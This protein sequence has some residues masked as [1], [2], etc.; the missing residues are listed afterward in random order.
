MQTLIAI[1]PHFPL[2]WPD[3]ARQQREKRMRLNVLTAAV[4]AL[5]AATAT[6]ANAAP[7]IIYKVDKVTAAII[8]GHLVVSAS[9]AVDTGGWFNPRL[10]LKDPHA[11]EGDTAVIEFQATPPHPSTFVIQ[12]LLPLSTTAV[13]PLPHAGT[14]QVRV[15][16]E[17]NS[18]SAPITPEAA[19]PPAP[20][21]A[22]PPAPGR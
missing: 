21:P 14:T 22:R 17:N 10:H 13:F 11:A 8:R 18:I 5:A 4:F 3:W 19:A 1:A 20:A 7:K 6:A 9:G 12:A 2:S 16:A 15:E